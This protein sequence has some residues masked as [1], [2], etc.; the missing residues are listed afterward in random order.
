LSTQGQAQHNRT[1]KDIPLHRATLSFP[2][3]LTGASR[4]GQNA[5]AKQAGHAADLHRLAL[6]SGRFAKSSAQTCAVF[7]AE[8]GKVGCYPQFHTV[9]RART[10]RAIP[11]PDC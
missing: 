2:L 1:S 6:L 7:G 10:G 11:W 5:G 8:C 3:E 4:S 9:S